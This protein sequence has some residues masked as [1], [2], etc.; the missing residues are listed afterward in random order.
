MI[1][2]VEYSMVGWSRGQVAPYAVCTVHVDRR[3]AGFLVK[4]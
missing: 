3:R 1:A 4:P 2:Q